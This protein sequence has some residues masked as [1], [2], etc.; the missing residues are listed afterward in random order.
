VNGAAMPERDEAHHQ[1]ARSHD[2][3]AAQL[4]ELRAAM[5]AQNT[6]LKQMLQREAGSGS[7]N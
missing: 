3:L 2:V 4:T 5:D 7:E 1:L 6:L